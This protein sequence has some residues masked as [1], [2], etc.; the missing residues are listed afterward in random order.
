MRHG[1]AVAA[2][3][4]GWGTGRRRPT[5]VADASVHRR[6]SPPQIV[7]SSPRPSP[8]NAMPS[9]SP[10]EAV[11]G[12]RGGD[13]RVVVL[14]GHGRQAGVV[15]EPRREQVRVQVVR[16]ELGAQAEER[17]GSLERGRVG[18]HRL[19]GLQVA[20]VLRQERP[21]PRRHAERAVQLGARCPAWC[22]PPR[23][24]SAIGWGANERARRSTLGSRAPRSSARTR[25]PSPRCRRSAPRSAGRAAR[26][27]RRSARAA[28]APRRR[29]C[30]SARRC[31]LPLVITS[32]LPASRDQQVVQRGRGQHHALAAV[33]GRDRGRERPR[34]PGTSTIGARHDESA[35]RSAAE[36]LAP[37]ARARPRLATITANGLSG[38]VLARS[39]PRHRGLVG[40]V[41]RQVEP[42]EP[43]ERHD[44]PAASA[45]SPPRRRGHLGAARCRR[46]AGAD[47]TRGTR[48]A[49]HGSAGR[50]GPRTRAGSRRTA[51]TRAST[52]ARG[53]RAA[54]RSP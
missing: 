18:A 4:P 43:L 10:V 47:R 22:G 13:V 40:R 54:P 30:R 15:R 38:P 53:R 3:P 44:A 5:R 23:A 9:T 2:S 17:A 33:A 8:S 28:R 1:C 50:S 20:H 35:A 34:P 27:R 42:A 45:P 26:T 21:P 46:T 6:N 12:H 39:Q 16:D 19:G 24:S 49:R 29:R 37:A 52:C 48:P 11:L 31:A 41:A 25:A 32:G 14:H 7:P 51:G 36:T